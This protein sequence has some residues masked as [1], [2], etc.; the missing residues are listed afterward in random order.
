[1]MI[2]GDVISSSAAAATIFDKLAETGGKKAHAAVADELGLRQVSDTGPIDA[3]IDAM[4]ASNPKS[5][6]DYKGGKTNALGSLVGMIMKSGKGF[7]PKFGA[8]AVEGKTRRVMLNS[9]CLLIVT[10]IVSLFLQYM[11]RWP[12][13]DATEGGCRDLF[14]PAGC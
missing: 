9:F 14:A 13:V 12:H 4:I 10:L 3:A 5:L 1:M 2:D 11:Y 8:G 7:N 6:T